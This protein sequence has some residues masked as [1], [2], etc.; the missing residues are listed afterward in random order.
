MFIP[1]NNNGTRIDVNELFNT[2]LYGTIAI[3]IWVIWTICL[4]C[5]LILNRL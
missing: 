3:V 5:F 1:A 4:Y 2:H